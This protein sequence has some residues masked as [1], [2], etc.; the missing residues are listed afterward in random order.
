MA[1][2]KSESRENFLVRFIRETRSEL[3]KV[4]W[5][6]RQDTLRMSGIVIGVTLSMAAGL[7]I[8][9]FLFARIIGLIVR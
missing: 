5:P 8:V 1:M 2:A 3:K 4:V 9:D 7:A 6:S